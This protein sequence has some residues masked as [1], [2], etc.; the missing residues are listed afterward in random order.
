[1]PYYADVKHPQTMIQCC[2]YKIKH[3]ELM[4]VA[5]PFK[6]IFIHDYKCNLCLLH[7]TLHTR[8]FLYNYFH[9]TD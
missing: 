2:S 8:T 9:H 7:Y 6:Q 4:V 5:D 3:A 1:M